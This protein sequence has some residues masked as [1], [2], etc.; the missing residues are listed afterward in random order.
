MIRSRQ[1]GFDV[2]L[3]V[4]DK[5]PLGWENSKF[6]WSSVNKK[7]SSKGERCLLLL[8]SIA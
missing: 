8:L 1:D 2:S 6:V 7:V 5:M 4:Q 3:S